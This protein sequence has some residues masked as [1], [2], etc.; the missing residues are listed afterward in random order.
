MK[1]GRGVAKRASLR[2]NPTTGV[3]SMQSGYAT[4]KQTGLSRSDYQSMFPGVTIT[5]DISV[6]TSEATRR[7][8][9]KDLD[10]NVVR[11][12]EAGERQMTNAS[13]R[14]E[15][16]MSERNFRALVQKPEWQARRAH[17]GLNPQQLNGRMM[18]L[19]RVA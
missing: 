1:K 17:L 15:M 16:G 11:R 7:A 5:E 10:T 6:A 18:G 3:L 4:T 19:R 2:W 9:L 8:A 13:L 14:D 12:L